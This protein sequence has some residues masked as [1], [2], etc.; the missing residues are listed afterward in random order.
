MVSPKSIE[1]DITKIKRASKEYDVEHFFNKIFDSLEL[2]YQEQERIL[3]GRPDCLIGE[4]IVDFKYDISKR[5]LNEWVNSKGRQYIQEYF[6]SK[7]NY[8]SLLIVIS[9]SY[10]YYYDT[11]VILRE[12]REINDRSIISLLEL[13]LIHI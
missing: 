5:Q 9:E 7:G 11:D 8:P 12:H 3:K 6:E 4:M 2:E 1:I 13:S 10:I